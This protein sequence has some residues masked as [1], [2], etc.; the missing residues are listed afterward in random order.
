MKKYLN[1]SSVL[2]IILFSLFQLSCKYTDV[3]IGEI[4]DVNLGK[5][6]SENISLRISV[7]VK[8]PNNYKITIV[9][10]N[11]SVK[12][13]N[14]NFESLANNE[15]IVIPKRYQGD[16]SIPITLKTTG[17]LN[18]QTLRT[19]YKIFSQKKVAVEAHGTINLKVF[20]IS[21]KIKI[22]EKR[23]IYIN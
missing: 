1:F 3:E 17:V 14:Q 22:E 4:K 2:F 6:E 11:L 16:L 21:K 20:L 15:N 12:I 9:K 10:Y 13:N 23:T 19:L 8:N 5:I 18:F 7:P